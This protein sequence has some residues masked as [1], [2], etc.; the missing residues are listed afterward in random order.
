MSSSFIRWS[1]GCMPRAEAAK[2]TCSAVDPVRGPPADLVLGEPHVHVV[3]AGRARRD[4]V[5]VVSGR[6]RAP[7]C[8]ARWR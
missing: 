5:T 6:M 1:S 8:S 2:T 4:P 3:A 7:F